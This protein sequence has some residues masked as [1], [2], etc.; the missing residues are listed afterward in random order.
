MFCD[1]L[2]GIPFPHGHDDVSLRQ[3]NEFLPFLTQK[4]ECVSY[5]AVSHHL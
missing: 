2:K 5:L 4:L 3:L 1:P